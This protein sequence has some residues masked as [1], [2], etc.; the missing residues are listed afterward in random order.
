LLT[1]FLSF[2][3]RQGSLPSNVGG[4]SNVRNILRRVFALLHNKGWWAKL[5][6]DGFIELFQYHK[7]DLATIYGPFKEY[8]VSSTTDISAAACAASARWSLAIL[9]LAEERMEY[10]APWLSLSQ[11]L[12]RRRFRRVHVLAR[13]IHSFA[14]SSAITDG[15]G[16]AAHV[17]VS[18]CVCRLDGVPRS[19][20][21]PS[22]PPWSPSSPFAPHQSFR[23]IIELEFE[24]WQTTDGAQTDKLNKLMQKLK[25][26]DPKMTLSLDDWIVCVSSWGIP[27]DQV[28]KVT[29]QAI[30]LNL[31]YEIASRQE[32]MVRA[33]A[34]QLY[35]TAHLPETKSLYYAN[36]KEYDFKGKILEVMLNV[37]D[38]SKP[39]IVVL[40]QSSFYPTSGGQEHDDGQMW[41]DGAEYAVVDV[42]KV[43]P[44]V[45][46]VLDPPLPAAANYD[47]Y[48]G[49][50]VRGLVNVERRL[51]LRN[52]HTATHIVYASCRK[53]LGPHVWQHGAKKSTTQAHLDITHFSSLSHADMLAIEN[54]AN[55]IVMQCRDITKTFMPKDVAES[56]YGFHLYQGGVVPGNEL[57]VVSIAETDTE[58]CCGTHADNTAEVGMIRLI[59]SARISDGIVRLYYVAGENALTLSNE[60][61]NIMNSL[62]SSWGI[63]A[64][65][66]L[67]TAARFF[68]GYKKLST[69]AAKQSS[70]ILD[71]E[72]KVFLLDPKAKLSAFES[73]E[74]NATM[75]IANMPQFAAVSP[76]RHRCFT[77]CHLLSFVQSDD[78]ITLFSK[79]SNSADEN[80]ILYMHHHLTR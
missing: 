72:M 76:R 23:P 43:G 69:L 65:D 66:I 32:K 24:R 20:C 7:Q 44:C 61:S 52:N 16:L 31:Y 51:Q 35:A 22:A 67:P 14:F 19:P 48:K 56:K 38:K 75:F 63:A 80:A 34:A 12:L 26:K 36:H 45:L 21:S 5:G 74:P 37:V 70:Q 53:V 25:A 8:K 57:R 28:A 46:H 42:M 29:K 30:P 11:R 73:S 39:N 18:V 78:F 47:S 79:P 60:D 62:T 4:A 13:L 58:A 64:E 68:D 71:L 10:R 27:A 41:I 49:K 1:R 40:D 55:R 77:S 54:Q 2:L 9:L 33:T 59:K 6:M 3:R 50:E 17:L 15:C